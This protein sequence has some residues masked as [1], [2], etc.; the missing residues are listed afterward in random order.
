[1]IHQVIDNIKKFLKKNIFHIAN[2][3]TSPC[4]S[5]KL[6]SHY[7]NNLLSSSASMSFPIND[8]KKS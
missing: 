5:M 1:M 4:I 6:I 2:F 8:L 7:Y 3:L